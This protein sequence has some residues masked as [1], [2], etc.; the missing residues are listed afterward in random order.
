[1]REN[2]GSFEEIQFMIPPLRLIAQSK[3]I[4]EKYIEIG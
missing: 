2:T 3:W 1:M 4:K